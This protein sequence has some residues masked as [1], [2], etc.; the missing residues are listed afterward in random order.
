MGH[1]ND[2]GIFLLSY[3]MLRVLAGRGHGRVAL[4]YSC[5]L[6]STVGWERHCGRFRPQ[7]IGTNFLDEPMEGQEDRDVLPAQSLAWHPGWGHGARQVQRPGGSAFRVLASGTQM[8]H[9]PSLQLLL[10]VLTSCRGRS[11]RGLRP[12][13]VCLMSSFM[14]A[15]AG[16]RVSSYAGGSGDGDP[17]QE[18]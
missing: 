9:C 10:K 4:T 14:G 18:P 17:A 5:A 13:F 12:F 1:L 7:S 3:K 16:P 11:P 8:S 6:R 2:K 15:C